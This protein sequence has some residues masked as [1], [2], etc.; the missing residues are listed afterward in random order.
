MFEKSL[1]TWYLLNALFIYL[2]I[3]ICI[4]WLGMTLNDFENF[5]AMN[6]W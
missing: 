4:L 3:Y 6:I 2:F 5:V 1:Y